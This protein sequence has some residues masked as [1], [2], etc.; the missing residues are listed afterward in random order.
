M[1]LITQSLKDFVHLEK[2]LIL[3]EDDGTTDRMI[4]KKERG[5]IVLSGPKCGDSREASLSSEE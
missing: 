3:F 1:V 5:K 2:K 4:F